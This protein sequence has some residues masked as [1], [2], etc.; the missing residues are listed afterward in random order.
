ML[1]SLQ[2]TPAESPQSANIPS[3]NKCPRYDTKQSDGEAPVMEL[4]D[5]STPSLSLLPVLLW[6]GV[7][8]FERVPSMSQIKLFD[9]LTVS[10][11]MIDIKLKC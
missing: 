5:M 4:W 7:E 3:P 1:L 11:L 8:V 2:N 9:H 10:K 6:P